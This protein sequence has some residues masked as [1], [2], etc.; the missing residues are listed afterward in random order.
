MS[1]N[2]YIRHHR[3]PANP[4]L[5]PCLERCQAASPNTPSRLCVTVCC[6]RCGDPLTASARSRPRCMSMAAARFMAC[7]PLFPDH[8][9]DPLAEAHHLEKCLAGQALYGVV[10]GGQ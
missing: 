6:V 3:V 5:G 8:L 1:A 2:L 4:P 7:G 9:C 10:P